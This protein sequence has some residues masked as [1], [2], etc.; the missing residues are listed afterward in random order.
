MHGPVIGPAAVP[1]GVPSPA[2]PG[3]SMEF[4]GL[5]ELACVQPLSLVCLCVRGVQFPTV[6][7]FSTEFSGFRGVSLRM[8]PLPSVA[9]GM[10]VGQTPAVSGA[11]GEFSGLSGVSSHVAS[12][13]GVKLFG[14]EWV[15]GSR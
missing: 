6:S 4:S 2:V 1:S 12:L 3:P 13:S 10:S 15:A 14:V 5:I 11:P 8:A 7:D 9:P